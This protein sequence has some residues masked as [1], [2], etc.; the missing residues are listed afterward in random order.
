MESSTSYLPKAVDS[1]PLYYA[2]QRGARLRS[3]LQ[4]KYAKETGKQL[5]IE[6]KNVLLGPKYNK[7]D[8]KKIDYKNYEYIKIIP[9]FKQK[10]KLPI[11]L[12]N[13]RPYLVNYDY[14]F[15]GIDTSSFIFKK[16]AK[17]VIYKI[18]TDGMIELSVESSASKIPVDKNK[19]NEYLAYK[20]LEESK[21]RLFTYLEKH[22]VDPNR[23]L[24]TEE[25]VIVQGIPYSKKTP[26]MR[27]KKYQYVTF[28]PTN[29]L[30]NIE[31]Q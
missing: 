11:S 19:S 5:N 14:Y 4:N 29:F 18:Q 6:L 28:V 8:L 10:R 13:V 25:R 7:R 15:V 31:K 9:I 23:V 26:I 30:T 1:D 21:K 27:Y 2:R 16:F 24:I 3:F 17:Y 20:H 12:V 22:L